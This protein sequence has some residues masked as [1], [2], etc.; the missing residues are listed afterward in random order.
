MNE[1]EL[2]EIKRRFRP[3][4]SNIPKIVG[5]FVN[6]NKEIVYRISQSLA[7]TDPSVSEKLLSTMKKTLS[8][9]LGTNLT[10]IAFSTKDVADGE[11]HK[12]LMR[13]RESRLDDAEA[14]ESFY[15]AAIDGIK[16][17]GNFVL[18]LASDIYDVPTK[19]SDGLA[20]ESFSVFSYVV[21]AVCPLK[22]PAEALSFHES[23]KSFHYVDAAALLCPPMLG[24][25][26]PAFDDRTANIYNALLYTKSLEQSHA[27]FTDNIF[28]KPAPTPPKAQRES[29]SEL[30]SSVL[31]EECDLTLIKS[32]HA[33]V[34]E[35]VAS[36]KES[37]DPEPL[38]L[39]KATAQAIL[40]G[41]GVGEE[42]VE[43]FGTAMDESFGKNAE[44]PPKNVIS[45][46]RMELKMPEVSIKV[47]P[48][49]RDLV[50]TQVI[51]GNKYV[52]IRVDG[53]V[54]VNGINIE[55]GE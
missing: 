22:Q 23:D 18:L 44:I 10:D 46:N 3:E 7:L 52:M 36:H 26:F 20:E 39:N 9:S 55:I 47:S 8:G 31:G 16:C 28:G 38:T 19:S 43:E 5:C 11:K 14:L 34:G 32:V 27:E 35:M 33:Q 1:R 45:E 30:L 53:G 50:S 25:M 24:F 2:R 48:E 13:L 51:G 40:R 54:E 41:C 6:S 37:R 12:L 49:H 4:R 17:E 42:K 29:F 21:C 15:K